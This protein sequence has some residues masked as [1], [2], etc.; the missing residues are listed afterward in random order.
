[1]TPVTFDGNFG[2]VHEA[3]GDCAVVMCSA[4]GH[5]QL[6]ASR[7]WRELAEL[8]SAA[9]FPVLRFDWAGC[10]DSLGDESDP[11]RLEAWTASLAAAVEQARSRFQ[12]RRII[13][14]GLRLGATLAARSAAVL[15]AEGLVLLAPAITGRAY[16]RELMAANA[17]GTSQTIET[18]SPGVDVAGF[19]TTQQTLADLAPID[20]RKLGHPPS[21]NVLLVTPEGQF[22]AEDLENALTALGAV[23]QRTPFDGYGEFLGD[24]TLSQSP[25]GVFEAVV[26]WLKQTCTITQRAKDV[27][28]PEPAVFQTAT[29]RE[30]AVQFGP[31][32]SLFGIHC[33]PV[34]GVANG[35]TAVI[36]LNTGLNPH[37]GWARL[38]VRFARRWADQGIASLRIDVGGIGDS[39]PLP[40]R[41]TQPLYELELLADVREAITRMKAEGYAR[42]VL[43]GACSGAWLGF[44]TLLQDERASGL[45]MVNLAKFVWR[46]EFS[47]TITQGFKGSGFYLGRMLQLETWTRALRGNVN[48]AGIGTEL[49]RRGLRVLKARVTSIANPNRNE[50]NDTAIVQAAFR[51]LAVRNVPMLVA[52]SDEDAASDE[53]FLH[54]GPDARGL[55]KM[56]NVTVSRLGATDHSISAAP[57]QDRLFAIAQDFL[58]ARLAG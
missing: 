21:P 13:L 48:L 29:F 5:E 40:G 42:I 49:L 25:R 47:L 16:S 11:D 6:C 30:E 45:I 1:M 8:I 50:N 17:V 58:A 18:A 35:G 32:D 28:R 57:S 27:E 26:Q 34:T 14:L 33:R 3:H 52:F 36:I 54:F 15:G 22:Q 31:G 39:P 38:A 23:V 2:F 24:I 20:L 43:F 4:M 19:R 55:R 10:G 56:P 46:P 53:L 12:T 9:G 44:H 51:T 7:G 41:S 37:V